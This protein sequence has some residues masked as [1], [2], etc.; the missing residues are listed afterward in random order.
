MKKQK[1]RK[2]KMMKRKGIKRMKNLFQRRYK[3]KQTRKCHHSRDRIKYKKY[4]KGK[5]NLM[6]D[7]N[8]TVTQKESL[9]FWKMKITSKN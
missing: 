2:S 8:K 5:D 7:A 4:Q 3:T 9:L 6:L 1:E